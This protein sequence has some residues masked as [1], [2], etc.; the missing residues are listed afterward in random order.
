MNKIFLCLLISALFSQTSLQTVP[1]ASPVPVGGDLITDSDWRAAIVGKWKA[2]SFGSIEASGDGLKLVTAQQPEH[3]YDLQT[4]LANN[5]PLKKGDTLLI[6]FAARSLKA[7]TATG[8]TKIKAGFGKAT[9]PYDRS[10]LGEIGLTSSWQR[11]DI[12]FTCQNDFAPGEARMT[13]TFDYPAQVAE[14]ADLQVLRFP[15][16]VLLS[17]LPKTKRYADAVAPEVRQREIARIVALRRELAAVKDPAPVKGKII[18][19]AKSGNSDANGS[20]AKPFGTIPQALAI[21]QPGETILV[22]AGEYREPKGVSIKVSGRPDAWI[23]IK[24][25]PGVRPNI[26]TSS[27]SGIELRGGVCYIESEGFELQWVPDPTIVAHGVGVAPMYATH[28]IRV[29]NNVIHGYG[30]GGICTLDC[31]YI[32]LEGNTIY[33]TAKTSP[34]G[35]SAI[36]LCRAFNF[37]D[38]PGHHN[39]VRR[40]ICFDNELKVVVLETSGGTGRT[41]TDGN[42]IIIDVFKRSR[43]NPLKPHQEDRNGPLLPYRGRTLIDNNLL[44]NNGGRGVHVFRSEKVDIINNTCYMN[45]KS[46]DINAGEL[47]AI[48]SGQRTML[49]NIAY[50]RKE[51]RGNTQDGS[52]GVL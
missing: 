18:H 14:V 24:A 48:E 45:Q 37:D 3:I 51:K 9:A 21:V 30:T 16:A 1:S 49:N 34:Y 40:N 4:H 6:R 52:T 39:V 33:D 12:P 27:W 42:G 38:A 17:S 15:A 35:G 19:V 20:A 32:Y 5:A 7:D 29:L 8:V 2:V 44:Y 28:H 46:A 36:S 47:T 50:G 25:A 11:Y 22:G 13:F 23:K 26:V 31:D 41:L 10:Y 43:A